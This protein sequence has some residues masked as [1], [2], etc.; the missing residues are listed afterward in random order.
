M[1]L[2]LHR[3]QVTLNVMRNLLKNHYQKHGEYPTVEDVC[4]RFLGASPIMTKAMYEDVLPTLAFD[5][6]CFKSAQRDIER[7]F[8]GISAEKPQATGRALPLDKNP[9]KRAQQLAAENLHS[10]LIQFT[11]YYSTL[12]RSMRR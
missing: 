3:R 6:W 11:H 4:N 10:D 9:T 7:L 2:E 5:E 12:N 1:S 8:Q